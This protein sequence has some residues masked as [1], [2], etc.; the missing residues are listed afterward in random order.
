MEWKNELV[1]F[2][3]S[4][5]ALFAIVD[6]FA[7]IPV[8]LTMTDRFSREE[9]LH[10]V[11]K[12]TI[13]ATCI[14]MAFSLAGERIFHLFG[15]SIP[16]FQIAGGILL[17]KLG[18]EQLSA[19]R[20]HV[21]TEEESESFERAD[22]SIFPIAT[23]LLA[24]PGSISTVVLRSSQIGSWFGEITLVLSIA[25][26]FVCAYFMLRSAPY[27]YRLMGHTGLNLLTRIMGIILTAIA[28]QYIIDGIS[29][30]WISLRA[31]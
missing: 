20:E 11:S 8:Y 5:T 30:V 4:F 6:P 22:I 27:L 2:F 1:N 28:V 29:A 18:I 23:P 3:S 14:L 7:L 16:A 13:V 21:K 19:A 24:G 9:R 17:L 25:L 31:A 15:I 12:A 10:V 26:V